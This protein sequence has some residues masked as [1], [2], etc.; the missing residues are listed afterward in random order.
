MFLTRSF[1]NGLLKNDPRTYIKLT[2]AGVFKPISST[3]KHRRQRE[4]CGGP[5]LSGPEV[6]IGLGALDPGV[7]S[8]FTAIMFEKYIRD[9]SKMGVEIDVE[10]RAIL[11][12]HM[13]RG[14]WEAARKIIRESPKK[15]V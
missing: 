8:G 11:R 3:T 14:E 12:G 5:L 1:F 7:M 10:D 15:Y 4:R 9:L 13:V 2:Q 6:D